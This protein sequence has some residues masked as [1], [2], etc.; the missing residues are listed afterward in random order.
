MVLS[1]GA[2][3]V[4]IVPVSV[5]AFQIHKGSVASPCCQGQSFDLAGFGALSFLHISNRLMIT[6]KRIYRNNLL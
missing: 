4:I 5:M 1:N 3:I 2:D 6:E